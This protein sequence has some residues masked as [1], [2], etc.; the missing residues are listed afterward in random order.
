[1][2][3]KRGEGWK[4]KRE[5]RKFRTEMTMESRMEGEVEPAEEEGGKDD[6]KVK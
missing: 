2:Q 4:R 1:M 6:R 5:G 3:R